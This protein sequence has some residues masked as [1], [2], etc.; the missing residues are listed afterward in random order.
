M[1]KEIDSISNHVI[2][3]GF[4]RIGRVLAAELQQERLPFVI[5]DTS[6]ERRND[7]SQRGLLVVAGDA[8]SDDTLRR[9]GIQRARALATVLPNDALNVFITLTARHLNPRLFL[10]ARG[11]D[12]STEEKL[13]RAGADRVVLPSAIGAERMAHMI[14]KPGVLEFFEKADMGSVGQEL[15]SIGIAMQEVIIETRLVGRTVAELEG[16]GAGG[17]LVVAVRRIGGSLV[18]NPGQDFRFAEEDRVLLMGH[19]ESLPSLER[20]FSS[21]ALRAGRRAGQ[22]LRGT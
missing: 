15:S 2:I 18:H 8:T 4:G 1:T 13:L 12:H 20:V 5:V 10:V 3:C 6:E 9:A 17:Y 16:C 19:R 21:L 11:E 14:A 22:P 7:A